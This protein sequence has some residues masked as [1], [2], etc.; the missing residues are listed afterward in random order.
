[1][2]SHNDSFIEREVSARFSRSD[3]RGFRIAIAMNIIVTG[4]SG[5]VGVAVVSAL[6]NAGHAVKGI[7]RH[8]PDAFQELRW[9]PG[10]ARHMDLVEPLR[11]ADAVVHLIGIIREIPEKQITFESMHVGITERLLLA[12]RSA[13]VKRLVHMSALGTRPNAVSQYHQTKWQAEQLVRSA[14]DI[15][16]TIL[17]PSLV[18]GGSPP[19]FELLKSLAKLPRV[20]VP[21]DGQTLFQPVSR[22]DIGALIVGAL[23]DSASYGQTLQ[24]GGPERFTLNQLIDLMASKVGRRNPAK[25]HLPLAMVGAVARLSRVLPVPITPDQ[26]AMLTEANTTTDD[27][28]HRWV[29]YPEPLSSWDTE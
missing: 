24:V 25:I 14:D 16:A 17:R 4:A 13:G 15:D 10:D 2:S 27:A 1:M 9:V 22:R 28:W 6:L 21:G 12:M 18:F 26:L 23:G 29:P 19:F 5:Y 3:R 7:S 20:P 11:G 8:K